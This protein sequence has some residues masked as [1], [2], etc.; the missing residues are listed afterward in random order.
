METTRLWLEESNRTDDLIAFV[1]QN[2]SNS[3]ARVLQHFFL[4]MFEEL[5]CTNGSRSSV[6]LLSSSNSLVVSIAILQYM[7]DCFYSVQGALGSNYNLLI[8]MAGADHHDTSY[9]LPWFRW[10]PVIH[11][12][13]HHVY[14]WRRVQA[15]KWCVVCV[16]TSNLRRKITFKR[17]RVCFDFLFSPFLV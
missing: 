5:C 16:N 1:Q 13:C 3:N 4:Q 2:S 11:S 14:E 12:I 15:F 8:L 7:H 6:M 17:S 10:V 9:Y